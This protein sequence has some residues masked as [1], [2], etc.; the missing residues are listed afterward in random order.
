MSV[1]KGFAG[2]FGGCMG[3]GCAVVA[4]VVGLPIGCI[5]LV[6]T[7]HHAVEQ[8]RNAAEQ[9]KQQQDSSPPSP[10]RTA[11]TPPKVKPEPAQHVDEGSHPSDLV[12]SDAAAVFAA[13]ERNEVQADH[14][15][16]DKWFAVKG[17]VEKIGKDIMNTPY[18]ALNVGKELS[19]F[20]VQC[21][22]KEADQGVLAD[23]RPGQT[24]VIGGKCSGKMGNVLMQECWLYDEGPSQRENAQ[25]QAEVKRKND[26]EQRKKDEERK[27]EQ[28]KQQAAAEAAKWRTWTDASGEHKIEAKF[29]GVIAG[30]VKL[31]KRDGSTLQIPLEKLSDEDQDWINN[32]RR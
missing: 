8:A 27:E 20:T 23:L 6:G 28:A 13:Y 31:I 21:M 18:V 5:M 24:V 32:R 9:A 17:Q 14:D 16:K 29:G 22:F 3:V 7:T 15:M 30:K 1:G 4:V 25:Q 12:V 26:E 2:G 19:I 10:A 11:T